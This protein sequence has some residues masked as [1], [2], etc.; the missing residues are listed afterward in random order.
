[1]SDKNDYV[2]EGLWND[3]DIQFPRLIAELESLGVFDGETI[4]KLSV[5]MDLYE[6]DVVELIDRAQSKWDYIKRNTLWD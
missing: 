1:M 3:D 2:D 6:S 5:E 4:K